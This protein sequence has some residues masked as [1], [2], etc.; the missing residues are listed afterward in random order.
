MDRAQYKATSADS[1]A[2]GP[3][4]VPV[5]LGSPGTGTW[6]QD[7]EDQPAISQALDTNPGF[8]YRHS[9][10][11]SERNQ[12]VH[13]VP[14]HI[15]RPDYQRVRFPRG[16]MSKQATSTAFGATTTTLPTKRSSAAYT[17]W[18]TRAQLCHRFVWSGP[19][20]RGPA[21]DAPFASGISRDFGLFLSQSIPLRYG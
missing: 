4:P 16:G 12:R 7:V 19:T 6:R 20:D 3:T 10:Q 13:N 1:R 21:H 9:H 8:L 18:L 17:R 15:V 2:T 14:P 5:H 11:R